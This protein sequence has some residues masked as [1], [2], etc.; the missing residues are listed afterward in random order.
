MVPENRNLQLNDIVLIVEYMQQRSK[1]VLGRVVKTFPDKSD[2]V[3]TISV[4]IP[5]SVITRP[6]TKFYLILEFYEE[7]GNKLERVKLII[8]ILLFCVCFNISLSLPA[9]NVL[10]RFI[11]FVTIMYC[12]VFVLYFCFSNVS[13]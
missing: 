7:T 11:W 13:D 2:V 4:K 12:D 3:R 9:T 5:S 8:V 10:C 1:W 6:I